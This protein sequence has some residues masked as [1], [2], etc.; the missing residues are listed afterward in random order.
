M[1]EGLEGFE[2]LHRGTKSIRRRYELWRYLGMDWYGVLKHPVSG[3]GF[4]F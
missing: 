3:S 2:S 4:Y 1:L